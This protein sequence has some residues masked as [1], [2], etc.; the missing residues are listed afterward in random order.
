MTVVETILVYAVAP[1]AVVL[2][3]ALLTLVP[4]RQRKVRYKPGQPWDH[5]PVWYEPHPVAGDG[6]GPTQAH[7]PAAVP[8]DGTTALGSSMYPEQHGERSTGQPGASTAPHG[9]AAGSHGSHAL[10]AASANTAAARP[11]G[12]A[13]GTW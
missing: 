1:L 13:R 4:G 8:G 7:G 2:L 11:Y 12:G 5:E 3:F 10:S 6:H 9:A